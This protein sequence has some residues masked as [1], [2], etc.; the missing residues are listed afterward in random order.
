MLWPGDR[1]RRT[2]VYSHNIGLNSTM[3]EGLCRDKKLTHSIL[4]AAGVPVVHHHLCMGSKRLGLFPPRESRWLANLAFFYEHGSDI[5]VKPT[6]GL[7]GDRVLR[8]TSPAAL[9]AAMVTLDSCPSYVLTPFI[10]S[11]EE[12]RVMLVPEL[13]GPTA[14][15]D[16]PRVGR[17]AAFLLRKTGLCVAGDGKRPLAE[18]LTDPSTPFPVGC[19]RA[20]VFADLI[21]STPDLDLGAVLAPGAT[22]RSWKY[23]ESKGAQFTAVHAWEGDV[24]LE[25]AVRVAL[26]AAA[27][28]GVRFGA[29]DVLLPSCTVLE[30]NT[31]V[32]LD[33]LELPDDHVDR[34]LREMLACRRALAQACAITSGGAGDHRDR[35]APPRPTMLSGRDASHYGSTAERVAPDARPATFVEKAGLKLRSLLQVASELSLPEVSAGLQRE[36]HTVALLQHVL[37]LSCLLVTCFPPALFADPRAGPRLP[38]YSLRGYSSP[39]WRPSNSQCG[40]QR[41]PAFTIEAA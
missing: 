11:N 35:A 14:E 33:V 10:A 25:S 27:A 30:V 12:V 22:F 40:R 39:T 17:R 34:I 20:A 21:A 29:V 37:L 3:T 4:L 38:R 7:S 24:A 28:L 36:T 31:D 26:A 8:A 41:G 2:H 15:G 6:T 5:V 9:E 13:L 32:M 18:L 16:P 1:A 19:D 23:N